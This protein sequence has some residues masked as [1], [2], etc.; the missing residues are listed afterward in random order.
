MT[1]P[2]IVRPEAQEDIQ[3]TCDALEQV[4]TGLGRRFAGRLREVFQRVESTPE[5]HGVVWQD[6][7]AARV[8]HFR[9]VVYYVPFDDRVEVIAVLHGARDPSVWQSRL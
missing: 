1:T 2:L 9:Y 6:V 5:L 7:R 8:K 4:Q 3:T